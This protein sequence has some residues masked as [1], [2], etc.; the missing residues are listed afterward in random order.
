MRHLFWLKWNSY[1]VFVWLF[2]LIL[3]DPAAHCSSTGFTVLW[4]ARAFGFGLHTEPEHVDPVAG[5]LAV[6]TGTWSSLAFTSSLPAHAEN[7][8]VMVASALQG[9]VETPLGPDQNAAWA[10]IQGGFTEVRMLT[11]QANRAPAKQ[12]LPI[13]IMLGFF[14]VLNLLETGQSDVQ[15]CPAP[16]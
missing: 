8:Q 10:E 6:I 2:V 9:P 5:S 7:L 1:N 15:Q 13:L 11:K 16:S 4:G 14:G 12:L 3:V